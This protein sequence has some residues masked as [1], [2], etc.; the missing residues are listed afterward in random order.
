MESVNGFAAFCVVAL[1]VVVT[2]GQ[3]TALTIRNTLAGGRR[4]GVF[5]ALGVV[6]GQA[7]W[8]VA[9]AAGLAA[10][11]VA[12]SQAF[13]ALKLCGAAYLVY[14]GARSLLAAVR[15]PG[16]ASPAPV[17]GAGLTRRVA[18]RQG[19]ISNLG[20]PKIAA[21]FTT[22]LPQFAARHASFL[23]FV[24][25]GAVLCG[26][27]LAW[28]TIYAFVVARTADFLSR[29]RVRRA[30]KGATGVAL[31]ALGARLAAERA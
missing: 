1:L 16:P 3:D 2:P 17:R 11:L 25:H 31:V 21:F 10:L 8:S 30:L 22:L 23:D 5:S 20:N 4:G 18:Y 27:T 28:L 9:T 13:L 26:L 24:A 29:A 12:S 19:L 14:L 15:R 7:T 6:T